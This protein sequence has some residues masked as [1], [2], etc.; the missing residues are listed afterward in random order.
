ML[1]AL[2]S[3]ASLQ[4]Y[5]SYDHDPKS[6]GAS[7]LRKMSGRP[8]HPA[9]LQSPLD[10]DFNTAHHCLTRLRNGVCFGEALAQIGDGETLVVE[11]I[12]VGSLVLKSPLLNHDQMG[13]LYW[14]EP[15][16]PPAPLP[17]LE[18]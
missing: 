8:N 14:V 3:R 1:A 11:A 5:G 12:D 10:D 9:S 17:D 16:A 15:Y 13:C 2:V 4:S 18:T 6:L 7:V